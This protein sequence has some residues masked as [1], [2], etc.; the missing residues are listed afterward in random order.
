M[1]FDAVIVVRQDG[2]GVVNLLGLGGGATTLDPATIHIAGATIEV[3][4]ARSLLPTRGF[5]AGDYTWN[6]W[7]RD[8]GAGNTHIADFAP[9]ASNAG[10]SPVPAP[11][12]IF[13]AMT[14]MVGLIGMRS[15]RRNETVK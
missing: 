4:I 8:V 14:G 7:P 10:F 15:F 6:L 5:A 9:D 12:A 1:L 11:S 2:T 3:D 13:L